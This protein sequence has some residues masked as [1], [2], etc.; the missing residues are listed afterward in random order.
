MIPVNFGNNHPAH[1]PANPAY[2]A[3]LVN[4][5][6]WQAV[7]YNPP[8]PAN[9][10]PPNWTWSA[11]N[12]VHFICHSQGGT[13]IR[14]LIELLRGL[15]PGFAIIAGNRQNWAKSVV[16]LGTPHK[17]TT[18]TDVVQVSHIPTSTVT[19]VNI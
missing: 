12:K 10:L 14:Y 2:P 16:T 7:V 5:Q 17:G 11:A 13:T 6:T 18:V 3:L 8:D 15:N 1:N 19:D 9:S 4:A